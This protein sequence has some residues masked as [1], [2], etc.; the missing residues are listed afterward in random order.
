MNRGPQAKRYQFAVPLRERGRAARRLDAPREGSHQR[1]SP[2]KPVPGT[3]AGH[4]HA[5]VIA[6]AQFDW[7]GRIS[8]IPT[9]LS[10]LIAMAILP[11]R[12]GI[13]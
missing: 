6:P 5:L 12:V 11:S 8:A 9:W 13:M 2:K 3:K 10:P 1:L 4:R 7:L